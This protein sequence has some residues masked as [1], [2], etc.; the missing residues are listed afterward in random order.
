MEILLYTLTV[1]VGVVIA[2]ALFGS[3]ERAKRAERVLQ[4]LLNVIAA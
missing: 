4:E 3:D 2:V 1:Y